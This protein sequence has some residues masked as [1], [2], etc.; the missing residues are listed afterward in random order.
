MLSRLYC[1]ILLLILLFCVFIRRSRPTIH[2]R[3]CLCRLNYIYKEEWGTEKKRTKQKKLEKTHMCRAIGENVT[4]AYP[5]Y[6]AITLKWR[7]CRS[8]KLWE[9]KN[10]ITLDFMLQVCIY[11]NKFSTFCWVFEKKSSKNKD[12]HV[13]S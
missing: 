9:Q 11:I 13:M 1:F 8:H 4:V 3:I 5:I 7:I 10:I 6:F 2:F 12:C